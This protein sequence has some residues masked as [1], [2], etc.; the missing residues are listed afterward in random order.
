MESHK[1]SVG[2]ILQFYKLI[3]ADS[4]IKTTQVTAD[5]F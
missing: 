2:E 5:S 4:P 1:R 3:K